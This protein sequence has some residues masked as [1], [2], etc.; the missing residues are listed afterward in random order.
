MNHSSLSQNVI[1]GG[2]WVGF[3]FVGQQGFAVIRTM[4][5]ARVLTPEDFGQLALVTLTIFA[6]M[7][8]TEVSLES[9][10]RG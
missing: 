10:P 6:G 5:L 8:L 7:M 2:L 1:R 9:A 4:I 3:G